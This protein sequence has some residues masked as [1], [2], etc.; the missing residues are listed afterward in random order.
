MSTT[1]QGSNL[2]VQNGQ[3]IDAAQITGSGAASSPGLDV[4]F[5]PN[6]DW[7]LVWKGNGIIR[8]NINVPI[9]HA[10]ST[11]LISLSEFSDVSKPAASR[12]IGSA[13][14]AIYNIA[15]REGGVQIW[16]EVNWPNP[17]NIYFSILV[18]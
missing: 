1:Y 13:R 6:S 5:A 11:V 3:T 17:I 10:G 9:I 15:P 4:Q 14:F 2:P 16:A 12:F 7:F 18:S 8:L